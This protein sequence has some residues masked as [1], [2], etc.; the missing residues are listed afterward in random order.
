M[1]IMDHAGQVIIP[2]WSQAQS[3]SDR[4]HSE[5]E[6]RRLDTSN[7]LLGSALQE[8]RLYKITQSIPRREHDA[9]STIRDTPQ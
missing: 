9:T 1:Y 6:E 4:K 3:R 5:R 2:L 7:E 8:G